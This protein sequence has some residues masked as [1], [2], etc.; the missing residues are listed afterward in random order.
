ML[1]EEEYWNRFLET[2]KVTDY[3]YYKGMA[4]CREVM[5]RYE[6]ER[7]AGLE[8]DSTYRNGADSGACGRI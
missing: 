7:I 4:I 3:L 5:E 6:K 8:S 2:G 1:V